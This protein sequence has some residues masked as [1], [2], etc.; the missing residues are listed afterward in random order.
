MR[1]RELVPADLGPMSEPDDIVTLFGSPA[2]VY[3]DL[4]RTAR[5][6]VE[7]VLK[8][9]DPR[10]YFHQLHH[11]WSYIQT[12]QQLCRAEEKRTAAAELRRFFR[13]YMSKRTTE[14]VRLSHD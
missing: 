14:Q 6:W 8:Q 2:F 4:V 13:M 5:L 12:R 11:T 1:L 7:S 3:R 10:F 9:R